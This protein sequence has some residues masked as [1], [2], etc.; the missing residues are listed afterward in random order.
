MN[1]KIMLT[2]EEQV[3][4]LK[5]KGVTFNLFREKAAVDYL[6]NNNNFFKLASYRKN[7]DKYQGGEKEG[8]Y[9]DLDF[10]YLR[11]LATID[12]KLRYTLVQMSLDVEHYSK[13]EILRMAEDNKED[14][15]KICEDFRDSLANDEQRKRF[16][17]EIERNRN[18]DYCRDLYQ[19]YSEGFPV[20]VMLEVI[21]FGRM[22]EFYDFCAKRY[23]DKIMKKRAYLLKSC[24]K[25]RNASAHSSCI[26]NDLRPNS[27]HYKSS[28]ELINEIKKKSEF[29]S[30]QVKKRMSNVRID[31]V[32]TMLYTHDKIVTSRGV[33]EKGK[34]LLDDLRDRINR[35]ITYYDNNDLI[36]TNLFFLSK[37]IDIWF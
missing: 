37:C 8:Q 6:R 14:A 30:Q 27:K 18:S 1:K 10:E 36:K 22:V 11:D 12:M 21:P 29:S 25:I 28:V 16:D 31:Q 7:Y 33:H 5:E 3:Q 4:H 13:L 2:A 23:S 26:L 17:N 35:N 9:I 15:Y 19:R 32:I 24:R 34:A 20:W